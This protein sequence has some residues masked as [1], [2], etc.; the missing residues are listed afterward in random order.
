MKRLW[1]AISLL[2]VALLFSLTEFYLVSNSY[3]KYNKNISEIEN[4]YS[5]KEYTDAENVLK[6]TKDSWEKRQKILKV[7]LLHGEVEEVTES[8]SELSDCLKEK[9]S[10]TF[11]LKCEKTKRQLLFIKKSE[12]PYLE[13]IM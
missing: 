5:D 1:V 12:L 8:L 10:K 9:D 6:N 3:E 4:Y 7:F 11:L 2:V 13:N